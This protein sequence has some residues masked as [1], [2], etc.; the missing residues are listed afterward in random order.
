MWSHEGGGQGWDRCCVVCGQGVHVYIQAEGC[1]Y[2][3][4][5]KQCLSIFEDFPFLIILCDLLQNSCKSVSSL[6]APPSSQ[7]GP[8]SVH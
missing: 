6:L 2:Q 7:G 4:A 5:E 1:K 3:L 8:R